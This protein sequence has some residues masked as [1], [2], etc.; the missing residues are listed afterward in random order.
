MRFSRFSKE[1]FKKVLQKVLKTKENF[2]NLGFQKS[3]KS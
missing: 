2:K 3:L 1:K